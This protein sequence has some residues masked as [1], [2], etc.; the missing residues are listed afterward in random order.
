MKVRALINFKDFELNKR[1]KAGDIYEV[2]KARAKV[3][4]AGNKSSNF[5]PFVEVVEDTEIKP[6]INNEEVIET[7]E[8]KVDKVEKAI[9][10]K[11]K[12]REE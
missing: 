8:L 7:A 5:K 1:I 3:L 4:L 6:V 2:S 9:R 11:R 10:P 12:K